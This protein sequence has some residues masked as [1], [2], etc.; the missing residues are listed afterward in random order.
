MFGLKSSKGEKN[1][2]D[3]LADSL[4]VIEVISKSL[5]L[6]AVGYVVRGDEPEVLNE[7]A[8]QPDDSLFDWLDHPGDI[9]RSN[10]WGAGLAQVDGRIS[11]AVKGWSLA[12]S[13]KSRNALYE[14]I[15]VLSAPQIVRLARLLNASRR[16]RP[17]LRTAQTGPEWLATLL[18]DVMQPDHNSYGGH[19]LSESWVAQKRALW[20]PQLLL[21]LLASE[22]LDRAPPTDQSQQDIALV[23]SS[24]FDRATHVTCWDR[25]TAGLS[26]SVGL[27]AFVDGNR[28][29]LAQVVPGFTLEGRR[30][31]LS[32]VKSKPSVMS[33]VGHIVLALVVDT[34]KLVRT[35]AIGLISA[36]SNEKRVQLLEPSLLTAPASAVNDIIASVAAVPEGVDAL[37]RALAALKDVKG[38]AAGRRREL[39]Q[40]AIERSGAF[41]VE[42]PDSQRESYVRPVEP[43]LGDEFAASV[44]TVVERVLVEAKA[45]IARANDP[46]LHP[47]EKGQIKN[48]RNLVEDLRKFGMKDAREIARFASE[49][50]ESPASLSVLTSKQD[51]HA[52]FTGLTLHQAARFFVERETS[53]N[54]QEIP[55]WQILAAAGGNGDVDLRAMLDAAVVAG[56]PRAVLSVSEYCVPRWGHQ[57]DNMSEEN[58]WPFYDEHPE[59]LRQLLGMEVGS[60]RSEV[61]SDDLGHALRIVGMMPVIPVPLLSRVTQFALGEGKRHRLTAQQLLESRPGVVDL[62]LGALAD[63]KSEIRSSAAAWL[64]R[65]NDPATIKPLRQ[66]LAQERRET[67]RAALLTT[68]E[69]LGDDITKELS[70]AKLQAEALSGLK[71]KLPASL[72]WFPVDAI[73]AVKWASNN[74]AVPPD[75]VKWWLALAIKLKNPSGGGIINRYLSLLTPSTREALGEFVLAAWIAQDTRHPTDQANRNVAEAEAPRRFAAW[76]GYAQRY[77]QM[78]SEPAAK[79]TVEMW[80]EIVRREQA[81]SY[82]GTAVNEK[83]ILALASGTRGT[84]LVQIIQ[85]F[86]KDHYLKRAQVEALITVAAA[87]EDLAATQLVLAT[88]R[89][90]RTA[91]VQARARDL[92]DELAERRGWTPDELADRTIPTAGFDDDSILR[93]TFG[94]RTFFG[95]ISST[96]TIELSE[97]AGKVIKALPDGRMGESAELV[98]EAKAQLSASRKEFKQQFGMQGGRLYEAMC[99]ERQW[100]SADFTEFLVGHPLVSRLVSRLVWMTWEPGDPKNYTLFR[101]DSDHNFIDASDDDV[102]LTGTALVQVAHASLLSEAETAGWKTHLSD[103]EVAPLFDQ[104]TNVTPKIDA[105]STSLSDREGWLTDTFSVRGAATRRGY[106]RGQGEDGGWFSEYLKSFTSMNIEVIIGFTGNTLPEENISA[107]ITTLSFR[108]LRGARRDRSLALAELPTVLLAESY[109]D[110]LA[111]SVSGSLDADWRK[112]VGW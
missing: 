80:F 52:K 72:G 36:T 67:V 88:S 76:Q 50:G 93:L 43:S 60:L 8:G 92:V 87:S 35:D 22:H 25:A 98:A 89:R 59:L 54:R 31:F 58:I 15:D 33:A 17:P 44:L 39:L 104:F 86:M 73:P 40:K 74:K 83:G 95:R 37:L 7:L 11:K 1:A 96:N 28:S 77:P 111:V 81:A 82:L 29:I 16:A 65:I 94:D 5:F 85:R 56:Y 78:A 55:W 99:A 100:P 32:F 41:T 110:Y 24:Y 20:T 3:N 106:Q 2:P 14:R 107:A 84:V 66:A 19:G 108:K 62:A 10:L 91:S 47:W 51:F 102:Q 90:H 68:L 26:R 61:D 109:A 48:A 13:T 64:G 38:A 21:G 46:A 75:V 70:P 18:I 79:Y 71:G 30:E 103:Y 45:L 42:V 53:A 34:S 63:S 101:P 12:Q 27:E 105:A 69:H 23:L 4:R 57:L 9:M 97:E 6:R 49:G 112:K